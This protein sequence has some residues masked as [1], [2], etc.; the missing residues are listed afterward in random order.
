MAHENGA[1]R[2]EVEGGRLPTW[3]KRMVEPIREGGERGPQGGE[4]PGA[5]WRAA[6]EWAFRNRETGAITVAQLPNLPM[7][8]FL[9]ALLAR[10]TL[11]SHASLDEVIEAVELAALTWWAYEEVR[12]G[13][14]PWRRIL[15]LGGFVFVLATLASHA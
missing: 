14:N 8:I 6:F 9:C 5:G 2:V 4:Q 3:S 13:V 7:W 11:P 10:W 12:R 1:A 15:G